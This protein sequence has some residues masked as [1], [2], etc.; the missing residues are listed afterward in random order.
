M[1]LADLVVTLGV[2][3]LRF[4]PEETATFALARTPCLLTS[5]QIGKLQER[6]EGWIAALQLA[7]LSIKEEVNAGLTP[8]LPPKFD[9]DIAEYLHEDVLDSQ[10]PEVRNFLRETS[11]LR[12][13]NGSLCDAITGSTNGDVMLT[14]LEAKGLFLKR[15]A[16]DD[17]LIWYRCHNLFADFLRRELNLSGPKK[18]EL[19]QK[20]ACEWFARLGLYAEAAEHAR[21]A[22]Q[23]DRAMFLLDAIAMEHIR[24]GRLRTVLDWRLNLTIKQARRYEH[25]FA[26]YLWAEGFL[27]D[28]NKALRLLNGLKKSIAGT[29]NMSAFMSDTLISLPIM[30][31]GAQLDLKTMRKDGPGAL[32]ALTR[33]GTFEHGALSSCVAYAYVASG[34][35]EAARQTQVA[36]KAAAQTVRHSYNLAYTQ[37]TEAHLCL[38]E[39]QPER[40]IS[41]LRYGYQRAIDEYSDFSQS[42]AIAAS[43]YANVLYETGKLNEA[44]AMLDHHLPMIAETIPDCVVTGYM[45]AANLAIANKDFSRA[46][47]ILLNGEGLGLRRK[48]A[49]IVRSMRWQSAWLAAISGDV[50]WAVRHR[51]DLTAQDATLEAELLSPVDAIVRDLFRLRIDLQVG[52]GKELINEIDQLVNESDLRQFGRRSLRLGILKSASLKAAGEDHKAVA[53]MEYMLRLAV[54]RGFVQCFLDEG[55]EV[56]TLVRRAASAIR[57]RTSTANWTCFEAALERA[58]ISGSPHSINVPSAR[59]SSVSATLEELTGREAEILRVLE[60][61]LTNREIAQFFSLSENTV[62]WHLRNIFDKLGVGNRTEAVF[63]LRNDGI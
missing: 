1:R 60:K 11:I 42:S 48:S 4:S 43:F 16:S 13:L 41:E 55:M 25:L 19:L 56:L 47:E 35:L 28:S 58:M 57:E 3:D 54:P 38:C 27:G 61:G 7:C 49:V 2:D 20:R 29:V 46:R 14:N 39:L 62:K 9:S 50:Q 24:R 8:R 12:L 36:A 5:A 44:R 40:A 30:L 37:M 59:Q 23:K 45:T 63:L 15:V 26:A 6:T 52:R 53:Q 33:K 32:K 17:G 18:F 34:D 10:L 51:D 31:A 21:A 22:G